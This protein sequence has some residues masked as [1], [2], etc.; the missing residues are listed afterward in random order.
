MK[1]AIGMVLVGC[2]Y[3]CAFG[4]VVALTVAAAVE[5]E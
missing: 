4:V 1:R 3:A 5:G 2:A